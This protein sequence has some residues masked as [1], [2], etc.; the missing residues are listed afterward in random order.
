MSH[1]DPLHVRLGGLYSAVGPTADAERGHRAHVFIHQNG[2]VSQSNGSTDM[3]TQTLNLTHAV[4]AGRRVAIRA[5]RRSLLDDS[6][7]MVVLAVLTLTLFAG[8]GKSAEKETGKPDVGGASGQ[9]APPLKSA[10][11]RLPRNPTKPWKRCDRI[12]NSTL[13]RVQRFPWPAI[14]RNKRPHSR[15]PKSKRLR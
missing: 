13:L 8:C 11:I 15:R 2:Q 1:K 3:K 5:N 12:S 9:S 14:A 10:Q 4:D 6:V 7:K